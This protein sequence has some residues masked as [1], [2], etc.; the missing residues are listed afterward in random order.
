[1]VASP[2]ETDPMTTTRR[3]TFNMFSSAAGYVVPMLVSIGTTPLLL[4]WLG[5]AAYGLNS[6]VG[7]VIG[8]LTFMDMGL[9]IPII[10]LL[11]ED[12]ARGDAEAESHLLSTTLQL[13]VLIGIAGMAVITLCAPMFVGSVFR[14]PAALTPD[15]V[16]VFRLA[17]VGFLGSVALSWGRA[18]AM[19]AQR[20]DL[21]YSVS[22]TTN[23]G[24]T[25]IGL[26]AVYAGFGIVGYVLVRVVLSLLGG[27][28]YWLLTRWLL[29]GVRFRWGL[30]R[31]TLQRVAGYVG[32]GLINRVTGSVF[33]RLDQTLIGVWVGVAAA[34]IY[35]V[36]F[37][38]VS[39]C[40]YLV[41][42]MLGFI[43]PMASELQSLGQME[44]LR[45]V[46]TRASRFTAALGGMIFVPLFVLG[47]HFLV[48]WVP[49]IAADA[50]AVLRLLALAT[51]LSTL[52]AALTNCVVIGT[53][54]IRQ[55]TVYSSIRGV[56]LGALCVLLIR[57]LGLIGAGWALLSV[58]AVDVVYLAVAAQRYI[59]I[60]PVRL[61][62]DAYIAPVGVSCLLGLVLSLARPYAHSW[63]G[64]VGAI[65][66]F[67]V[68]FVMGGC[69]SGVFG[70]TER[71]VVADLW[72]TALRSLGL[73]VHHA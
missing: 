65:V 48:L 47:D 52:C 53:G 45:T 71:R 63:P 73:S 49:T 40:G 31:P 6:L 51:Y 7:V 16:I 54:R 18:V 17:G 34:G 14:V 33:G 10:K 41:S 11:A 44:R 29:P 12:R 20:F 68:V 55:F 23:V 43:F 50:S 67:E 37:M 58:E 26:G 61:V 64:L 13:Y 22:I 1:M 32:Y 30:H 42:Y 39:S 59:A 36:P 24:G 19:G 27:P 57:P 3:S 8:Y 35:S 62:R 69:R 46:F 4:K 9:D 28:A 15:A 56:V 5:P 25:L 70:Q 2:S 66:V 21:A 60:P 38:I 72:W